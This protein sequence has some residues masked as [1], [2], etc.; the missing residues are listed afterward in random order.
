M[1]ANIPLLSYLLLLLLSGFYIVTPLSPGQWL[2]SF[3]IHSPP[4]PPPA[5]PMCLSFW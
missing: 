2:K 1:K 3:R 4:L 5:Q